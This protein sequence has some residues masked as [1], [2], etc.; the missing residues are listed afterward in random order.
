MTFVAA[1]LLNN[2]MTEIFHAANQV[3][4]KLINYYVSG[5]NYDDV[6]TQNLIGS[7]WTSGLV[8]P[9]KNKQGSEEALL[10]EQGKL[11]TKDKIIFFPGS[12]TLNSSGIVFGLG[13]PVS[14]Y[15]A[16]MQDGISLYTVNG[17][18]IY[19]KVWA[20][21]TITGSLF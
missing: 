13:S 20:R 9:V 21:R 12:T 10:I 11:S 16:L 17:S 15:Y 3:Y 14:D 4:V 5:T 7:Y 18:N 6:L 1:P 19:K 8:F 2:G